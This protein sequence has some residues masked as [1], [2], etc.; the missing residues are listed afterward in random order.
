MELTAA[1]KRQALRKML[2]EPGCHIAPSCNDGIQARLVE[3]LDF[4]LVHISDS[5][6]HRALGFADAGN[7]PASSTSRRAYD[8][9]A[10]GFGAGFN[11][12]L[13]VVSRGDTDAAALCRSLRESAPEQGSPLGPLLDQLF[14]DWVPRS[15]TTI[16]PGYLAYVPGGGLFTA[17]LADFI[18]VNM[19]AEAASGS[20]TPK[21]A[22][23]RAQKRAERYYKV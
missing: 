17:A 3:W 10:E 6:Q 1:E 15:F 2:D 22:A 7:D 23:E 19:V 14:H 9:L 4:P 12:P 18:V 13:L 16:G 21:E 8:L 11:G 5:G 20:K